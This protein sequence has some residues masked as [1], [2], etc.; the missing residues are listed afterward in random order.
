LDYVVKGNTAE[1]F[2]KAEEVADRVG[3]LAAAGVWG[4]IKLNLYDDVLK[5]M[6]KGLRL[7]TRDMDEA[8]AKHKL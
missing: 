6:Q 1:V 8:A 2:A 5:R 3:P 4:L 7:V